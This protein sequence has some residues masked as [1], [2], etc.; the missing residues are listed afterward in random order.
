VNQGAT[1]FLALIQSNRALRYYENLKRTLPQLRPRLDSAVQY[2]DECQRAIRGA[3]VYR[4]DRPAS[5]FAGSFSV[6]MISDGAIRVPDLAQAALARL[7]N[8]GVFIEYHLDAMLEAV[9]AHDNARLFAPSDPRDHRIAGFL[10][11][12]YKDHVRAVMWVQESLSGTAVAAI[13]PLAVSIGAPGD[14]PVPDEAA[15][16]WPDPTALALGLRGA[17]PAAEGAVG[18]CRN[19]DFALMSGLDPKSSKSFVTDRAGVARRALA[20]LSLVLD[21]P[22]R[23]DVGPSITEIHRAP[24]KAE[25]T[26]YNAAAVTLRLG[27]VE[28]QEG[29]AHG[30]A[31]PR[32]QHEVIGHWRNL[33]PRCSCEPSKAD[34]MPVE[35]GPQTCLVCSGRRTFVPEHKRGDPSLGVSSRAYVK[36]TV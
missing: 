5:R 16:L 4:F 23:L 1:P 36:V 13:E 28:R 34:W 12:P 9:G 21:P 24:G 31:G 3:Q 14:V 6:D 22:R 17:A 10:F 35:P 30:S 11:R 26:R 32:A 8:S 19:P 18:M 27:A 25:R 20:L 2:A 15:G 29:P 33:R 7:P